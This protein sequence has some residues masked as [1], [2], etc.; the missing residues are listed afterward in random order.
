MLKM[1]AK[2]WAY[3]KAPAA[4]FVA[5]HPV[6]TVKLLG[7]SLIALPVGIW[8]GRRLSRSEGPAGD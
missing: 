2:L 4:T 1:I 5:L 8:I 7:S 3:R 6:K